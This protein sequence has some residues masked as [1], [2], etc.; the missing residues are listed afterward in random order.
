LIGVDVDE[1]LFQ[2]LKMTNDQIWKVFVPCDVLSQPESYLIGHVK[3]ETQSVYITASS[4]DASAA[5]QLPEHQL[6]GYWY[7]EGEDV[8]KNR[9]DTM[10]EQWIN[11]WK[12]KSAIVHCEGISHRTA[13]QCTVF[14]YRPS[15]LL[16]SEIL[17]KTVVESSEQNDS[18]TSLVRILHSTNSCLC[19]YEISDNVTVYTFMSRTTC[20]SQWM[21]TFLTS[22]VYLIYLPFIICLLPMQR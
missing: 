13:C 15:D 22:F 1:I 8:S 16:E 6:I 17:K 9:T 18:I 5:N 10:L 12:D 14:I 4:C 20:F 11:I 2:V 21:F 3:K 19:G 7:G